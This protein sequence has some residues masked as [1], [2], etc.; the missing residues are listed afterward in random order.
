MIE[1]PIT[2][3]EREQWRLLFV[4]HPTWNDPHASPAHVITALRALPR[5]LAENERLRDLLRQ[6]GMAW[7]P[8]D[9]AGDPDL[10]ALLAV[11]LGELEGLRVRDSSETRAPD[12]SAPKLKV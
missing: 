1:Q 11:T 5:L 4:R 8:M 2:D 10:A 9:L 7:A 3:A 12:E 6:W